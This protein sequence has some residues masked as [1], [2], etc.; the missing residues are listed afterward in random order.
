MSPK[1]RRKEDGD[2]DHSSSATI[3]LSSAKSRL[4][5]VDWLTKTV[6]TAPKRRDATPSVIPAGHPRGYL[7]LAARRERTSGEATVQTPSTRLF[8]THTD[9]ALAKWT[10]KTARN[11]RTHGEI[12]GRLKARSD[13]GASLKAVYGRDDPIV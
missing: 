10:T 12:T 3:N 6:Q 2:L 9:T 8:Q 11:V 4:L 13:T 5:R 1:I 7:G